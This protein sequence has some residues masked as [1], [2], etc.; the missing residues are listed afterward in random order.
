MYAVLAIVTA[1]PLTIS[2]HNSVFYHFSIFAAFA[3]EQA[4]T[5][6]ILTLYCLDN[7]HNR[8]RQVLRSTHQTLDMDPMLRYFGEPSELPA[9]N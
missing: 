3:S 6:K 7:Q 9:Q 1:F 4:G 2:D 5:I 8:L